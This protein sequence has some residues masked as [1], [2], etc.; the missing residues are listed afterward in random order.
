MQSRIRLA[1]PV[2]PIRGRKG[3][4]GQG[5]GA[6]VSFPGAVRIAV[7]LQRFLDLPFF[8]DGVRLRTRFL[9]DCVREVEAIAEAARS[10]RSDILVL[11]HGGPIAEPEDA[12]YILK[13]VPACD[14]FYG[15]S[16][17]ERLPTEKAIAAQ[18]KS[19]AASPFPTATQESK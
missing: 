7:F 4:L 10:V 13:H 17:M 3:G 2:V 14:G 16:S 8:R 5:A 6:F 18:V 12:R 1:Q 15:A 19:F 11:S 9:D